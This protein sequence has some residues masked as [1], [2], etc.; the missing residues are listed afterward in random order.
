[1]LSCKDATK[2]ISRS[3]DTPLPIVARV[4]LRLHLVICALCARYERQLLVVREALRHLEAAG[5]WPEG[6]AGGTLSAGARERIG[7]ALR[8]P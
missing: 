8:N 1:M 5:D 2:L 6:P 3:M 7:K 4:R